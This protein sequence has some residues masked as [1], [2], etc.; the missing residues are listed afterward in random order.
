MR[1]DL[2]GDWT[3][4]YAPERNG[5]PDEF[6]P[7]IRDDW[8]SIQAVVPGNVEL[9]L[10]RAGIE[11]DPFFGLNLHRFAK[12][13]YYQW[14]FERSFRVPDPVD[15]NRL[16]LRFE[17]IDTV[18]DI[19]IDDR[20]IGQARNMFV[21]HEFDITDQVTPGNEHRIG[22]HI[23]S[24]MNYA[25]NRE[26]TVAMRGTAHRNEICW[27][28]KAPHCFGW[29]IAP[30]LVSAGLWRGVSVES[31]KPTRITETYYATPELEDRGIWL[32]YA[33][34][35]TTDE[36][37]LEGFRIR[38]TGSSGDSTFQHELP[39]HFVSANHPVYIEDPELWWPKGYGDQPLYRVVMELLHHDRVVDTREE[40][41]GLR[42]FRLDRSFEPG[43]QRFR[44][45]V[46]EVPIFVKGTNWVPLDALHSR[47]A[48][49]IDRVLAL[50]V[51]SGVNMI[52]CWGGNVYE[53]ARLFDLCDETGI[54]IWQDFAMGNTNYPQ[55]DDFVPELEFEMGSFIRKVRNH[56]SL[57]IWS[58]DNEI[59]LKNMIYMYPHY[60]SR[61]NRVSQETIRRILQ[62]HDPYRF[63][64]CSSPEI[65]EGFG[66]D[67]VP[68]QHTWG[69]RAWFKDDFYKHSTASFIGEAGYHGCPDPASIAKF[70]PEESLWPYDNETW[71]VHSTED[72][73]IELEQNARNKLMANQVKLMFGGLPDELE[74]F[75]RLSQISQAEAMKFFVERSRALKW[76]RSG[77]IWWNMIDCWP[78]ISDSVVDYY[79]VRKRAFFYLK[80][81]QSPVLVF[82]GELSHWTHEILVS[83]DT[84]TDESITYRV[85]DADA[86][87]TVLEGE[88]MVPAGE[89]LRLGRLEVIGSEQRLYLLRWRCGE[90]EYGNHY[91]TGYPPYDPERML[92]WAER[93]DRLPDG[94]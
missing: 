52:R 79:F 73:R 16:I 33:Y 37:T 78:Q 82:F 45:Y 15:G 36:D 84:R 27:L 39:A 83:N 14:L 20:P 35:F 59:D 91:I 70:I 46:N 58:S 26:Y 55:T 34:R 24:A 25:R 60:D 71:A 11:P 12:Y 88:I 57:A 41:V 28:R 50:C 64:L 29:D 67:D 44:I 53:E 80:R 85:E 47:D 18:A 62:A 92:T 51:D 19:L 89:N 90:R 13:E 48:E 9:D 8:P 68:E 49:R 56:P 3:L 30:R 2:N 93:I 6:T 61:V 74:R 66:T 63:Y 43:N 81:S 1:I 77:I 54:M 87:S 31:Q 17:G 42:T 7:S 40:R 10:E 94:G 32:Q 75:A 86:G 4:S 69:A 38:V 23:H 5:Q 72:I 22:V 65:P 21:D 76:R